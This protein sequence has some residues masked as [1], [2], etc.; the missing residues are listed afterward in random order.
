MSKHEDEKN[1]LLKRLE[2]LVPTVEQILRALGQQR[3][4]YAVDAEFVR[5]VDNEKCVATASPFKPHRFG[6]RQSLYRRTDHLPSLGF[7]WRGI[8]SS[9]RGKA[10]SS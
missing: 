5:A 8:V 7:T 3:Y 4:T 2:G 10:R 1:E 6:P 9:R